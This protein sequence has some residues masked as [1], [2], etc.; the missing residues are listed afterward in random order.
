MLI[1]YRRNVLGM[2]SGIELTLTGKI[3]LGVKQ[4]QDKL[5]LPKLL[6]DV[7]AISREKFWVLHW[8]LKYDYGMLN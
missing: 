7:F 6:K 5:C 4:N 8:T 1:W 2:E 3:E